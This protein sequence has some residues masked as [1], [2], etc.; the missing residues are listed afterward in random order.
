MLC[1]FPE[2]SPGKNDGFDDCYAQKLNFIKESRKRT[3]AVQYV[4]GTSSIA[5]KSRKQSVERLC[6]LVCC[7][8]L[9]FCVFVFSSYANQQNTHTLSRLSHRTLHL[10]LTPLIEILYSVGVIIPII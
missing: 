4:P 7:V 8:I 1:S 5:S 2:L 6:R 10:F 3:A 9:C